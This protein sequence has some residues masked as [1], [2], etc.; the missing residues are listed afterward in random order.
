MNGVKVDFQE[1]HD[2]ERLHAAKRL[3]MTATPR[4]YS[5]RSKKTLKSRGIDVVDMTDTRTYGPEL[6][7]LSFREAPSRSSRPRR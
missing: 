7:R 4:I 2:E 6:Y 3:Y 1:F 5:E